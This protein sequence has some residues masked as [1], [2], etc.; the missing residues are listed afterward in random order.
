MI[1]VYDNKFLINAIIESLAFGSLSATKSA[2]ATSV[3]SLIINSP[4]IL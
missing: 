3:L 4:L 1:S 2:N